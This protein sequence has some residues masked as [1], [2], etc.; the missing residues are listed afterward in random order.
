MW[1]ELLYSPVIVFIL[2]LILMYISFIYLKRIGIKPRGSELSLEP[3]ACGEGT[4]RFPPEK[5]Q[6]NVQLYRYALYFTIFDVAA[7]ILLLSFNANIVYVL[8]YV[9]IILSATFFLP[10]R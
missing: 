4:D 2:I 6:L 8:V 1:S 7:F 5:V 3:Y 10:K 9:G